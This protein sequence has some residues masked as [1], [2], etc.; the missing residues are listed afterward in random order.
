MR[1]KKK[2]KA[3]DQNHSRSSAQADRVRFI[4][5]LLD[6]FYTNLLRKKGL[7]TLKVP[8]FMFGNNDKQALCVSVSISGAAQGALCWVNPPGRCKLSQCHYF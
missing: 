4:F 6:K 1:D 8:L 2:V 5:H 7:V 3:S